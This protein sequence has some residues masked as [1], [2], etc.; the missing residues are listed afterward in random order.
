M[1]RSYFSADSARLRVISGQLLI[2]FE[3]DSGAITRFLRPKNKGREERGKFAITT[4]TRPL[5]CM[6]LHQ[7]KRNTQTFLTKKPYNYLS[8]YIRR[9]QE[10]QTGCIHY[11]T[12][13]SAPRN[14][15]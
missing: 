2:S 9:S 12:A 6:R 11:P 13:A 10:P 3:R 4:V 8:C 15:Y 14:Q 1:I 5:A 7:N